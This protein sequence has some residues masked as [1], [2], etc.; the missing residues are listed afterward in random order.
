MGNVS[1]EIRASLLRQRSLICLKKVT[2]TH[3]SW[4]HYFQAKLLTAVTETLEWLHLLLYFP[5]ILAHLIF[6]TGGEWEPL[7]WW[8]FEVFKKRA[9][10][11]KN[12]ARKSSENYPCSKMG[13]L[14]WPA[15]DHTLE[16]LQDVN[17]L[18]YSH[19]VRFKSFHQQWNQSS[20]LTTKGK[21]TPI[22]KTI[23]RQYRTHFNHTCCPGMT[24]GPNMSPMQFQAK[25]E[26]CTN[27]I[28]SG[29]PLTL[30]SL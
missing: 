15:L 16:L 21:L 19:A 14:R 23:D 24:K 30:K 3:L 9:E 27:L 2:M 7:D 13:T 28:H 25:Q 26:D 4:W 10:N 1:E 29:L 6:C 20:R 12:I 5:P 18:E 11:S 17:G 8:I 22:N